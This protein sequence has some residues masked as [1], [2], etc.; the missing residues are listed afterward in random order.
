MDWGLVKYNMERIELKSE[1][2]TKKLAEEIASKLVGGEVLA[3]VGDLGAG[4]TTFTQYL[5]QALEVKKHVNSPTFVVMK[6]YETGR[7]PLD[8]LVHMDAYRLSSEDE[9]DDLGLD[10]YIKETN[11]VVVIEWADKIKNYL[12]TYNA[13]WLTFRIEGDERSVEI[14]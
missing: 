11:S 13:T 7:K 12:D 1:G 14:N 6:I 5:A 9:L 2:D 8:H 4:K 3:L 10:Q